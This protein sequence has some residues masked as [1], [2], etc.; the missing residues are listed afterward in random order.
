MNGRTFEPPGRPK[1]VVAERS[2][3]QKVRDI[4]NQEQRDEKPKR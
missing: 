1:N 4:E 2:N 3:D